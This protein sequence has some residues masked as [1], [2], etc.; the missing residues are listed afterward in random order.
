MHIILQAP[1]YAGLF[2]CP[3]KND[4]IPNAGFGMSL[5]NLL[6]DGSIPFPI[7]LNDY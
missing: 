2:Y 4:R 3:N 5:Q 1:L 6:N 7:S